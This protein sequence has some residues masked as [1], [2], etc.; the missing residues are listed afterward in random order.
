ML[1]PFNDT[2]VMQAAAVLLKT[3]P[4]KKMSRLRLL[5]LLYIADRESLIERSRPI[6]GDHPAAMDHGPVLSRTYDLIK[7]RTLSAPQ[8][9]RHIQSL[10]R[11]VQLICDPGNGKLTRREIAKLQEVAQRYKDVNDWRVAEITHEFAEWI[12]NKP[13]KGSSNPIPLD[14]LLAAVGKSDLKAQLLEIERA[15]SAFDRLAS[16]ERR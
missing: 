11:D 3:E 10:G 9:D 5:K 13:A 2:K 14:D 16:S 1:I 12:K 6:T 7:G 15:E 8:W 4:D